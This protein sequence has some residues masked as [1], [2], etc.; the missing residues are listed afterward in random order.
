MTTAIA[1]EGVSASSLKLLDENVLVRAAPAEEIRASGLYLPNN[2]RETF[3]KGS[4]FYGVIVALGPGRLV[5]K[6]PP[7]EAVANIALGTVLV[8]AAHENAVALAELVGDAVRAFIAQHTTSV[9]VP[10]PWSVGDHV[11]CR[12]GFGPEIDLREGRHHLIGR[13]N[14]EH[15]HGIMAAWDPGHVHCWHSARGISDVGA[16]KCGCGASRSVETRLPACSACPSG[17]RLA[18]VVLAGE[19]YAY[20]IG[21]DDPV[22]SYELKPQDDGRHDL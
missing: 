1:M 18:E 16:A 9:R 6:A 21:R 2:A 5:E 11:L 19:I 12:Q 4:E 14:S 7:A 8:H 3:G 13:G 20:K 15:G 10:L 22:G 17:E